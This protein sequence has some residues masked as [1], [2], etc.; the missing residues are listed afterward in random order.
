MCRRCRGNAL[1]RLPPLI[2]FNSARQFFRSNEG[3]DE[4]ICHILGSL[5][6]YL[7]LADE[8]DLVGASVASRHALGKSANLISVGVGPCLL[9][10]WVGNELRVF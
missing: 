1:C 4:A 7:V 3:S 2:L 10:F 5:F 9:P 8:Y 6:R